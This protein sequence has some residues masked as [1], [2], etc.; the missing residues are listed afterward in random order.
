MVRRARACGSCDSVVDDVGTHTYARTH[1]RTHAHTC[2]HMHRHA[3]THAHHARGVRLLHSMQCVVRRASR[4]APTCTAAQA[5]PWQDTYSLVD[6][7]TLPTPPES[8]RRKSSMISCADRLSRFAYLG[9]T[10]ASSAARA[11]INASLGAPGALRLLPTVGTFFFFAAA[12]SAAAAATAA[13]SR[14]RMM[15]ASSASFASRASASTTSGG[16]QLAAY[17]VMYPCSASVYINE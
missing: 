13:A 12:A 4:I 10:G 17:S 6:G 5:R 2:T 14:S 16:L 7:V 3:H 11:A 8:W 15:R 1:A 9:S